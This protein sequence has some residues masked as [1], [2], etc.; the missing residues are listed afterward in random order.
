MKVEDLITEKNKDLFERVNSIYPV[1]LIK[2]DDETWSS[3]V[4]NNKAIISYCDTKFPETCF[5]HELLHI[6]TQINGYKRLKIGVSGFDTTEYFVTLMTAIDNELQHHKMFSSFIAMGY[7]K[8]NFYIDNDSETEEYLRNYLTTG[9]L[10]FKPTLLRYLT[11]I[12]PGGSISETSKAELKES[13]KSLNNNAFRA[14]FEHLDKQIEDWS[15]SNSFSAEPYLK[16]MFT[17]ISGG[18]VTWFGYGEA[19]EFPDNGFFVDKVF[20][21]QQP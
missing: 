14:Y 18:D 6:D 5:V 20:Q 8:E 12:A 10:Q 16:E 4:D 11:L 17:T 1:E 21:L 7:E 9:V 13:F 2:F 19:E 3:Q 15:S